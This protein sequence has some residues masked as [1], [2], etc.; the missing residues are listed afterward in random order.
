MY[1]IDE[2]TAHALHT[3]INFF[4]ILVLVLAES[5]EKEYFVT[6]QNDV[7]TYWQTQNDRIRKCGE[8]NNGT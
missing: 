7:I 1:L 3:I 6:T 2:F 4:S 8:L 5:K